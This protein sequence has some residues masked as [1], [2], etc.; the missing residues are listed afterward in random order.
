MGSRAKV[1]VK[2]IMKITMIKQAGGVLVPSSDMDAEK[3]TSFKTNE[4]YEIEIKRS[5]NPAFLRKVMAFFNFCFDH[6]DGER[7]HLHCSEIEQFDRFR[8]DLTIL[9]GFYVQTIRLDGTIRTEAE[10][11]A[12]A[13]MSEERFQ[14]CYKALI[15][16]AM[17]HI[18]KGSDDEIYNQLV[19]FF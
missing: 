1:R 10:S 18:F 14:E 8:K 3:L 12:F 11:L 17:K 5:R 16:A 4:H 2:I 15:S 6:W 9:S 7:S 19:R 13:S